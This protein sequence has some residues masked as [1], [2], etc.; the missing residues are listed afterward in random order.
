MMAERFSGRAGKSILGRV[1]R[2]S[3]SLGLGLGAGLSHAL[4]QGGTPVAG[5][6]AIHQPEASTLHIDQHSDRAVI[7][8]RSFDLAAQEQVIF[9]QP[10]T[11]SQVLNRVADATS[12]SRILGRIQANGGVLLVNPQGILFGPQSR[13][14]VHS[15]VAT[16]ADISN[17]S[18]MA[19]RHD[20]DLPG[21][22]GSAVIINRGE[23][24]AAGAG[25]VALVAPGVEN[26]GVIRARLG[27]VVLSAARSFTLDLHGDQLLQVAVDGQVLERATGLGGEEQAAVMEFFQGARRSSVRDRPI[28]HV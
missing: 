24:T 1:A 27:R 7:D 4:P 13:V 19:G 28:C 6:I 15:L 3:L 5:D 11:T 20:F 18:F 14:D 23:L 26:A 9:R 25:L 17:A 2:M 8:W 16:T 10:R 22:S 12:P 21:D